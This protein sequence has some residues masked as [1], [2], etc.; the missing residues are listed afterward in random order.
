MPQNAPKVKKINLS[1][2]RSIA[3]RYVE[4]FGGTRARVQRILDRQIQKA[5]RQHGPSPNAQD[6]RDQ[7]VEELVAFGFVDDVTFAQSRVQRGRRQGKSR[8]QIL[9]DLQRAG[10]DINAEQAALALLEGDESSELQAAQI[11]VRQ[12]RLGAYRTDPEAYED[13]D[14][15][16]LARRGFSYQIARQALQT[17]ET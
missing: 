2:L 16:R 10:L 1:R 6:W 13:K 12:R 4:R 15:T 5:E 8:K 14:L 17:R 3:Q 9:A 11:Y 7:V